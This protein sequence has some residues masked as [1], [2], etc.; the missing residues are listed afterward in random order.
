MPLLASQLVALN[1]LG[2]IVVANYSALPAS[3]TVPN[4]VYFCENSQGTKWLPFSSG[5]TYYSAG[6]YYSNGV[7]W[8]T[9]D[10]PYQAT[11][12]NVDA[13]LVTDQFVAPNTLANSIF[14]FTVAKVLSTA[15]SGL[16]TALTGVITSSD[17]VLIA[18]GK[19]QNSIT[20]NL[21]T[22]TSHISNTSNPHNV[23]KTQVGLGNVDNT[24]DI[25]KPVSIAQASA[26]A[27][28]LTSAN[29]YS[30]GKVIDSIA[31]SDTTHAPSRNAV[32]DALATKEP[33]ITG[34]TTADFWSGAKTF[35]NFANTV[36]TT[37]LTGLTYAS[38]VEIDATDSVLGAFGK[39]ASKIR[40]LWDYNWSAGAI[41][42]FA[43]TNNGN[44]TANIASGV[45]MLRTSASATAS[46]NEYTI[47]A[48]TN[49]TFT[50]NATNYVYADY[51]GG[52]PA[53]L[54]TT[55]TTTINSLTS[56]LLYAVVRVGTSLR[57]VDALSQ[58]VDSNGK[59]RR[60][61]LLTEKFQHGT[62]ASI[63]ATGLKPAITAGSLFA[64]LT[65][66]A[67]HAFDCNV[68]D[69][70]TY[71]YYNGTNYTR[72]TAQ[73]SID[74]TNYINAGVSTVM[75]NNRY[76]VDFIYLVID[77]PTEFWIVK[78]DAQYA[79]LADAKLAPTP[80]NLPPEISG[81]GML[82]GRAIIKKSDTSLSDLASPFTV[83]F[84]AGVSTTH[85]QLGGLQGGTTDEYY[86]LTANEYANLLLKNNY[87]N[88][89]LLMGA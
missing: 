24:S 73:T 34:T 4:K 51:N 58:N 69:T 33:T 40:R 10:L 8:K 49:Q 66:I 62:G 86:H 88:N 87:N 25:N 1:G 72:T 21:S 64:G 29:S 75:N 17:T 2:I 6:T 76:R 35:I 45:A 55:S 37:L 65:P 67:T 18:F 31:D 71:V 48:V 22:L 5:G 32:F 70:F 16:N 53:I 3:N 7:V 77:T 41:S 26:D 74:N 59:L 38:Y 68:S 56:T 83:G 47:S 50:D 60:R 23:T 14:A 28:V 52:S 13:G 39:L 81:L 61:F 43:F 89:F 78:G 11:Q 12:G 44:G 63:S 9:T 80:S 15:L 30:D 27:S 85:N 19:L 46:L 54:V 84:V 20:A 57:Y 82:V 79:N 42:G 36:R